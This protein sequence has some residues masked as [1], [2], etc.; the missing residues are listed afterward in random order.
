MLDRSVENISTRDSEKACCSLCTSL[1]LSILFNL[2]IPKILQVIF[3][4]CTNCS[5][6]NVHAE[7]CRGSQ[8]ED[9]YIKSS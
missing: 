2:W 6:N 3:S 1:D 7:Q 4:E 5:M 9:S 8:E